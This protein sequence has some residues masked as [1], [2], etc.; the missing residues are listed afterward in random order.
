M[1]QEVTPKGGVESERPGQVTIDDDV[2]PSGILGRTESTVRAGTSLLHCVH[3]TS[4]RAI[5]HPEA[6]NGREEAQ[7]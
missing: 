7:G 4:S 6:E 3:F 1:G 5:L 2:I